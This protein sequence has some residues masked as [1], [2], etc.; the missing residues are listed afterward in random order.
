[1]SEKFVLI[2]GASKGLGK[3]LAQ[4][5]AH[6]GYNLCL[7]SRNEVLLRKLTAKLSSET[8]RQV[9]PIVCDLSDQKAVEKLIPN[10]KS[11]VPSLETLINNAAIHGPIGTVWENNWKLWQEVIQVNLLAPVF[12]C[13]A[14]IPLMQETGGSIINI[15]GG[16]ATSPRPNFSAYATA[17][18][19]LVR[20][21]ETLAAEV[22]HFGIRVNCISPGPMK[23]A[24][25][26]EVV[27]QGENA[28]G[29]K[30]F[31]LA[32]EVL[33]NGGTDMNRVA[34]LIFFLISEQGSKVTGKLIS[35]VWD[36]WKMWSQHLDELN[37]SDVYTLR[38]ITGRDRGFDWGDK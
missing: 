30:E 38:R 22:N 37:F 10:V 20:F 6:L 11:L 7:I 13:R 33:K 18:A 32:D 14:C 12:L 25:L 21:S 16:G 9:I 34:D 36:D 23:T 17:K 31:D 24:L 3:L 8:G 29:Q 27:E 4:Y 19:G 35:A 5:L 26:S 28:S 15:S 1:M 2:T